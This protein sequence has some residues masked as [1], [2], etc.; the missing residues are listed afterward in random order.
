M[1]Q[2]HFTILVDI[3]LIKVKTI[4]NIQTNTGLIKIFNIKS[5]LNTNDNK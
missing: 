3:H 1:A 4:N 5:E 2:L